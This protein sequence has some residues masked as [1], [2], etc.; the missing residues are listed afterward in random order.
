MIPHQK[1]KTMLEII[2][3]ILAEIAPIIIA[4]KDVASQLTAELIRMA[5]IR[6]DGTTPY[7][8]VRTHWQK[9]DKPDLQMIIRNMIAPADRARVKSIHIVETIKRISEDI[10]LKLDISSAFWKQQHLINFKNGVYNIITGLFSN[11]RKNYIFDYVLQVNY[12]ENCGESSCPVFM[13]FLKT[14]AGMENKDCIFRAL[15]YIISSLT[16]GKVAFFIIGP[17]DGGKST[18]LRVLALV[19]S[20]ELI[21]NVGFSQLSDRYF[22]IQLLGKKINISYDNSSQPMGNEQVFKSVTSC[23]PI[24]G[25]ALRENPVQFLPTV[26]LIY[27]SNDPY[28]FKHPD[29]ALYRRMVMIPFAYSVPQDQRD[30]ELFNKLKEEADA[31]FSVAAQTLKPLLNSGY[32]FKMSSKGKAYIDTRIISLNSVAEF[33]SERVVSDEKG[34]IVASDL[35]KVYTEWCKYNALDAEPLK[36][37]KESILSAIPSVEYKKVGPREKRAWGFKG[38]RL[39]TSDELNSLDTTDEVK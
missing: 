18:L 11:D 22:V 5:I 19:V 1:G 20:K 16:G 39:K 35:H 33:V 24:E 25:R 28:N 31:I 36:M 7:I 27:A 15:G 4:E 8:D 12:L 17:P 10:S 29:E 30:P 3:A 23:E 9:I 38:I 14:S 2:M 34:R 26:K 6:F 21:S 37:F 13:K 32:D